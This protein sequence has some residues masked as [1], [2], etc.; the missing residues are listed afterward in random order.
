VEFDEQALPADWL[1][2]RERG[3]LNLFELASLLARKDPER[4]TRNIWREWCERHKTPEEDDLRTPARL[5]EAV[6]FTPQTTLGDELGGLLAA[7][8]KATESQSIYAS[9]SLARAHELANALGVAWPPE[10][11]PAKPPAETPKE[12]ATR[13]LA[14]L[15]ELGGDFIRH[16]EGWRGAGARGALAALAREEKAAGRPRSDKADIRKDLATAVSG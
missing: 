1:P 2:Y 10:L 3:S 7:L 5:F 11:S 9:V 15:K 12:R 4:L 8:K 6:N 16:G 13:R 14:R